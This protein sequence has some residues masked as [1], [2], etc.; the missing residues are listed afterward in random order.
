[1]KTRAMWRR[2]KKHNLA[3]MPEAQIRSWKMLFDSKYSETGWVD[4][5]TLQ[6]QTF[7]WISSGQRDGGDGIRTW[8]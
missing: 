7:P 1:M 4:R 8:I 5:S 2:H 6:M 3:M